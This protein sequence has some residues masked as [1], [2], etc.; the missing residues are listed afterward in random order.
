MRID[1]PATYDLT[2]DRIEDQSVD[3]VDIL[4]SGQTTEH[5]PPEQPI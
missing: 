3:V 4:V 2:Y 5:S 1:S